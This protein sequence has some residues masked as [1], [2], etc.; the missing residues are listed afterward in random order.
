MPPRVPPAPPGRPGRGS[1][2]ALRAAGPGL[3]L[4]VLVLAACRPEPR[5]TYYEVEDLTPRRTFG[6]S[7]TTPTQPAARVP[8]VDEQGA[9]RPIS[10]AAWGELA[11]LNVG[12]RFEPIYFDAE[13]AGLSVAARGRLDE[14]ADW[15]RDHPEVWV[16]LEGHCGESPTDPYAFN[17]AMERAQVVLEYLEATSVRGERFF[18][19]AF[20]SEHPAETDV[21]DT[22][23][24]NRVEL[25]VFLA[26]R[27]RRTPGIVAA[28]D[29][30]VPEPP[31]APR[32]PVAEPIIR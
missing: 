1:V 24:D 18:T 32:R 17:L 5:L 20:G 10:P 15:F 7:P 27:N 25:H 13:T 3:L 14:Y 21:G 2:A 26:P 12:R 23:L 29:D 16:T 6:D 30:E 9:T 22:A 11:T 31:P 19:I 4:L 28:Y 8:E